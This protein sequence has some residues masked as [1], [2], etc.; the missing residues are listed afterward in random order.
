MKRGLAL[1]DFDGT[2]TTRDTLFEIIIFHKGLLVFLIGMLR[3]SPNL[4]LFKLKM[5]SDRVAKEK[6]LQYFFSGTRS[7]DFEKLCTDFSQS[8]LRKLIRPKALAKIQHH[9]NNGDRIV[10]VSASIQNWIQGWCTAQGIELIATQLETSDNTITG[11]LGTPNCNGLEKVVRIKNYLLVSDYEPIYAYGN[12][13]GDKPMLDLA[14]H[15]FYKK[16]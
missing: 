10:V 13:S 11:K 12:S 14:D 1:F 5:V 3:L 7:S 6:V 2:I 4:V 16:F 15:R 9:K 8:Q